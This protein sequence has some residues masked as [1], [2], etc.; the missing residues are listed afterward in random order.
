MGS[1]PKM[2]G[3]PAA[4]DDATQNKPYRHYADRN[5]PNNILLRPPAS[6]GPNASDPEYIGAPILSAIAE[7]QAT[8]QAVARSVRLLSAPW[9]KPPPDA[10]SFH[11]GAG[12]IIP[13]IGATFTPVV[14]ITVPPGRNG[15]IKWLAN[16][17]VGQGFTDFSGA[18][19]WQILRNPGSGLTAAER[20]YENILYS[21]G[22]TEHPTKISPIRIFENDVIQLV[23]QNVNIPPNAQVIAGL[24]GGYYYPRTWDDQFDA[25]DASTAW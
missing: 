1:F 20:N 9:L 7:L 12:I 25:A 23:I 22:D 21:I 17:Y 4:S 13:A 14:S 2:V 6:N 24:F 18:L 15:V 3:I 5:L 10:E 11:V 19:I 16:K 8:M